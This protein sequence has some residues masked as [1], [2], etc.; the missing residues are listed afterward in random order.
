MQRALAYARRHGPRFVEEL[1]SFTSF[2]SLASEPA[3]RGDLVRCAL[4]LRDHLRQLGLRRSR[5][6]GAGDAPFVCGERLEA[7][8]LPCVL[9]YGHYDVQSACSSTH[10]AWH[11]PPFVPTVLG[12]HSTPAAH[13]MTRDRCSRT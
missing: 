6:V 12:E 7:P 8:G 13:R 4:W 2:P 10:E 3:H 5:L 9:V 1:K 11:T